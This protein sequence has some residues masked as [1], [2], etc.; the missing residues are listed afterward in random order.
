MMSV[1][2]REGADLS[3]E[4]EGREKRQ[5]D[6]GGRGERPKNE[7]R[8]KE[9]ARYAHWCATGRGHGPTFLSSVADSTSGC[10]LCT[11]P[12][13]YPFCSKYLCV[14]VQG[15]CSCQSSI[16]F[17][18]PL[19]FFLSSLID[20]QDEETMATGGKVT[21]NSC[22]GQLRLGNGVC[23]PLP[24]LLLDMELALLLFAYAAFKHQAVCI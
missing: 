13:S 9:S 17:N 24:A 4:G 2:L 3:L 21:A 23:T 10:N 16:Y 7:E 1:A 11:F 5:K 12:F 20:E 8:S 22:L 15:L 14:G 18:S 6:R 19:S